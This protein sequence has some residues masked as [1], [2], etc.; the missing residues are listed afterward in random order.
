MNNIKN[1]NG[2]V[3]PLVNEIWKEA[4]GWEGFYCVSNLGRLK[5]TFFGEKLLSGWKNKDGYRYITFCGGGRKVSYRVHRLVA[6]AF[7]PNPEKKK[8]VNHKFGIRDDNRASELEWATPGENTLHS[9]R[10]LGRKPCSSESINF[11]CPHAKL[12]FD[13]AQEIRRLRSMGVK[14]NDLASTFNVSS[15]SIW[16]II[17]GKSYVKRY[18]REHI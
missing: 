3:D 14:C 18:D 10:V 17:R 8:E 13:E 16:Q 11:K 6:I 7:I 12:T 2:R 5:S 1:I 4:E 15:S 9:Y